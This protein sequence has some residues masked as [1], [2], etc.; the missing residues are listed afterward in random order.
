MSTQYR[1]IRKDGNLNIT[2]K[3]GIHISDL[4]HD[5]LKMSWWGFASMFT[6][7]F[8]LT[9][10][11][12]GLIYF[13][14]PVDGFEGFQYQDGF[15]HY[16]ESFFF[17][18]QTFGTIGYGKIAPIGVAAN[19]VVTFESYSSL[20]V[21]AVLTGLVFARFAKPHSKVLFS[22]HAVVREYDGVPCF[23]FRMANARQN[24]I[25]DARVRVSLAIDDPKTKFRNFYDLKL[26][27]DSSPIFALSWSICH[28][29][30]IESPLHGLTADIWRARNAEIIVSFS[31]VD[32]TLSQLMHAKSSYI[33]D[34][35]LYN[36]DFVD[37][38]RRDKAGKVELIVENLSLVK[39]LN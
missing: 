23:M 11:F 10:A 14:L 9:N 39:N 22:H 19:L 27:R 32:T 35:V 8:F 13:F 15:Q 16:L 34:E 3:K 29:I 17:S 12:F 21:V 1:T 20:F 31:G 37:V 38:L 7:V 5:L 30:D 28:D 24:Y 25:T 6:A 26:E 4:Y 36:H 2:L 18:V 33:G